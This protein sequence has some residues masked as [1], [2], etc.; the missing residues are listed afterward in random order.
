MKTVFSNCQE[1]I[2][3]FAQQSQESGKSSNVF[4]HGKSIYSYGHH[5]EAARFLSPSLV[6]ISTKSYSITTAKH[7]RYIGQALSQYER[8][9]IYSL[10]Y[11]PLDLIKHYAY[12][13]N[14]NLFHAA[15]A[16]SK[17]DDY[18]SLAATNYDEISLFFSHVYPKEKRLL[19]PL[20]KLVTNI[21][22]NKVKSFLQKEKE[23]AL[24]LS[25]FREKLQEEKITLWK[26]NKNLYP[27]HTDSVFLRLK[28]DFIETSQGARVSLPSARRLYSL[29]QNKNDING[30]KIDD[31]TVISYNDGILKI[32]C[33]SIPQSEIDRLS[34]VLKGENNV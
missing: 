30:F 5:Y 14:D 26:N 9:Y 4:F 20:K 19:L 16:I 18:L 25:I 24:K 3:I 32:G 22:L 29:M 6:A 23:K 31:F 28:N 12:E 7:L 15:K 17:R 2:H 33:H 34:P 8:I 11:S 21:D 10:N 1:C 13:I 27:I